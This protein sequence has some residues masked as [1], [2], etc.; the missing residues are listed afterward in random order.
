MQKRS[1][2]A[3][4]DGATACQLVLG[5]SAVVGN[6][7]RHVHGWLSLCV[8]I[9]H[10][11]LLI[12]TA[13]RISN[14]ASQLGDRLIHLNVF[15]LLVAGPVRQRAF[16]FVGLH[17]LEIFPDGLQ[18]GD[19]LGLS[20]CLYSVLAL[21]EPEGHLEVVPLLGVEWLF[22]EFFIGIVMRGGVGILIHIFFRLNYKIPKH[23]I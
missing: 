21:Q 18:I 15:W 4:K 5:S 20:P 17:V 10:G 2:L 14:G 1:A 8:F 16:V 23:A 19:V 13:R 12:V 22:P 11:G 3:F 9:L 6:H 7:L